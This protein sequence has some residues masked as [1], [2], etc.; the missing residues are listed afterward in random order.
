MAQTTSDDPELRAF[1]HF[2][3]SGHTYRPVLRFLRRCCRRRCLVHF[4][5]DLEIKRRDVTGS[6][7]LIV[8]DRL[9]ISTVLKYPVF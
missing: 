8:L 7:V 5:R 2:T 4:A 3:K 9:V 6:R 1:R